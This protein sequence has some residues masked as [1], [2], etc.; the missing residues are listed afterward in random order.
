MARKKQTKQRK[1]KH[2]HLMS[3]HQL[4]NLVP[5]DLVNLEFYNPF[6]KSR[7][8]NTFH[9]VY[10]GF[11]ITDFGR[12]NF[13]RKNR[14]NQKYMRKGLAF[15]NLDSFL[16]F[17]KKGSVPKITSYRLN[18]NRIGKSIWT[19]SGKIVIDN[20]HLSDED[21]K[22]LPYR[23]VEECYFPNIDPKKLIE[24]KLKLLET[25]EKLYR[26]LYTWDE[27]VYV[28]EYRRPIKVEKNKFWDGK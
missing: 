28:D 27:V 26:E 7:H 5:G 22:G 10:E 18:R 21:G 3:Q 15:M 2:M 9:A 14:T 23:L 1:P 20:G 11:I 12:K 6:Q 19:E 8:L 25:G 17:K 24:E 13:S 4:E 16:Y